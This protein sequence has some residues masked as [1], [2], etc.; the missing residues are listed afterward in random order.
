MSIELIVGC[1]ALALALIGMMGSRSGR[2]AIREDSDRREDYIRSRIDEIEKQLQE[3]R[4]RSLMSEIKLLSLAGD[5]EVDAPFQI[6]DDC[7]ACG[8]CV[9]E[10]PTDAIF[11]GKIYWI[12][13]ALCTACGACAEVCPTAS[14]LPYK[15]IGAREKEPAVAT[16]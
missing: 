10:C 3:L 11:Q 12:D 7:V 15:E 1:A 8:S 2:K 13:P 16:A 14:C 9:E 6:D 5:L 4:R